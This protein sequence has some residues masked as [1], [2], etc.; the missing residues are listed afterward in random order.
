MQTMNRRHLVSLAFGLA[1]YPL[2]ISYAQIR[3]GETRTYYLK[4]VTQ[5]SASLTSAQAPRP[6]VSG[7]VVEPGAK[8]EATDPSPVKPTDATKIKGKPDET[9]VYRLSGSHPK[10]EIVNPRLADVRLVGSDDSGSWALI[11]HLLKPPPDDN[12]TQPDDNKPKLVTTQLVVTSGT[13]VWLY[14]IEVEVPP[15]PPP[16]PCCPYPSCWHRHF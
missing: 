7:S 3:A 6:P 14:E 1:V 11:V 2:G 10:F 8:T 13:G 4:P 9:S 16:P 12:Q 15:P 5:H